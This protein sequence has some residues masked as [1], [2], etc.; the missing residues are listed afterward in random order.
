MNLY[1]ARRLSNK[2][3]VSVT[4]FTI[5]STLIHITNLIVGEY[6]LCHPRASFFEIQ[7]S[8]NQQNNI[9]RYYLSRQ[10]PDGALWRRVM[11]GK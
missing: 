4:D 3:F 9:M 2:I 8:K 7:Y 1:P 10:W 5:F 11:A 6:E